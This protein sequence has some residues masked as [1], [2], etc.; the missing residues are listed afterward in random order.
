MI[1]TGYLYTKDK[2]RIFVNTCLG[3]NGQCVYCYLPKMGYDNKNVS[4][5][6]KKAE[7]LI[8]QIEALGITKDTL[9]TLGCFSECWDDNNKPE[10]RKLLEYFLKRG[11]QIQLSTKKEIKPEEIEQYKELVKYK[12]QFVIF[13][14]SA[15]ISRWR[16]IETN[17]ASPDRRFRIFD[18]PKDWKIPTVLYMK[19]VLKNI[20]MKDIELYEDIMRIHDI[21]DVVVGSIF[22]E[23]RS[24]ESVHFS[25]A[26][27]LFYNEISDE[28]EIKRR[29]MKLGNVRIFS[30]SSKVMEYYKKRE[31]EIEEK[32]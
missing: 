17:T 30:R 28:L 10:T 20:T 6:V 23:E 29:L 26:N 32:L 7:D 12:G 8:S 1:N 3:C 4:L 5:D 16:E 31:L 13:I 22:G 25:D 21:K 27:N 19:P 9:I 18:L 15:T 11:N 14:S 24:L 2:K